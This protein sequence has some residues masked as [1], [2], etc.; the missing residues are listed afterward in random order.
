MVGLGT[1]GEEVYAVFEVCQLGRDFAKL[2]DMEIDLRRPE[3][4]TS[5]MPCVS[6]AMDAMLC[7][8]RS[9]NVSVPTRKRSKT[10]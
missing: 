5:S 4:G 10:R 1:D 7:L 6:S 3:D 2:A 9:V 8:R